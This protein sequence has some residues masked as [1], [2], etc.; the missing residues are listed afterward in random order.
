MKTLL[1]LGFILWPLCLQSQC[2]KDASSNSHKFVNLENQDY[3][4]ANIFIKYWPNGNQSVGGPQARNLDTLEIFVD[5]GQPISRWYKVYIDKS[6]TC[7]QASLQKMYMG[8]PI[9]VLNY[10]LSK[11]W[12]L[13]T[14]SET[15]VSSSTVGTAGS[16]ARGR[17]PDEYKMLLLKN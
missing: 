15:I 6:P 11:G 17:N 9:A 16:A 5:F 8:S 13:N 14:Y 4:V 2:L 7:N 12:K 1:L 10:F 3:H